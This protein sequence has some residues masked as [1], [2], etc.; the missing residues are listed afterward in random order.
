MT[1]E[2]DG[3]E[4]R[5]PTLSDGLEIHRLI[6]GSPPLDL[7]S[8]Y[9]YYLF[10]AHFAE[11]SVVAETNGEIVGFIS[12]YRIPQRPDTLFVWQVVVSKALRGR[13][14]ARRMLEAVLQR[15]QA[16]ELG[17]VEATVNP[18]NRAS[19]SL[20]ERL[21]RDRGTRL[22]ESEFLD[23]A[24]FGPGSEHE[25]EILLRIPLNQ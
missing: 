5:R 8:V 9:S 25:P 1:L 20:F 12:A 11:T 22:L 24:A 15:H 2:K 16:G 19:R 6:A 10:G 18:S 17:F 13:Q 3:V 23:A 7:N 14:I 21:A 4:F